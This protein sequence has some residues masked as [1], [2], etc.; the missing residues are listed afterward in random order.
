MRCDQN[1]TA[2]GEPRQITRSPAPDA[3]PIWSNDGRW[4]YFSSRRTGRWETWRIPGAGGTAEQV[5]R[6]GAYFAMPAADGTLY[7][8]RAGTAGI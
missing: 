6:D 1:A 3:N 8:S 2:C 4:I 5:T 7:F